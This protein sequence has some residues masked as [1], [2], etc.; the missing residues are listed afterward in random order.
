MLI[1]IRAMIFMSDVC[2]RQCSKH[3]T[4]EVLKITVRYHHYLHLTDKKIDSR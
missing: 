2:S 4:Y 1:I 3:F